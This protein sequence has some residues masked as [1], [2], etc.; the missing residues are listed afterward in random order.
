MPKK[1][2][3]VVKKPRIAVIGAGINGVIAAS[4][5]PHDI[6]DV[7][8]F[9]KRKKVGGNVRT[10]KLKIPVIDAD[11]NETIET[12][13]ID[14]GAEYIAPEDVYP[15]VHRGHAIVGKTHELSP[16]NLSIHLH[17]LDAQQDIVLPPIVATS[18]GKEDNSKASSSCFGLF[19]SSAKQPR[20]RFNLI[21][22]I[23][24]LSAFIDFDALI[25]RAKEAQDTGNET[26]PTLEEFVNTWAKKNEKKLRFAQ[27]FLYPLI[28]G[29]WGVSIEDIKKDKAHFA[30]AYL[31]A[32]NRWYEA[33]KGFRS[34]IEAFKQRYEDKINYQFNTAITK[35]EAVEIEGVKKYKL[36][37]KDGVITDAESKPR[38]YDQVITATPVFI[39]KDLLADID[40]PGIQQLVESYK[41]VQSFST[42]VVIHKDDSPTFVSPEGAMVNTVCEG[43]LSTMTMKKAWKVDAPEQVVYK[44]WVPPELAPD[45][46]RRPDPNKV[47]KTSLYT[48]YRMGVEFER[49]YQ[50]TQENQGNSGIYSAMPSSDS[51][52]SSL[53]AGLSVAEKICALYGVSKTELLEQFDLS[54]PFVSPVP[55]PVSPRKARALRP[56]TEVIET[57]VRQYAM[58]AAHTVE[59]TTQ[60]TS[61]P[62]IRLAGLCGVSPEKLSKGHASKLDKLFTPTAPVAAPSNA[63]EEELEISSLGM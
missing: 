2:K 15:Y 46:K 50:I 31:T 3:E 8:V 27:E 20:L 56:S 11:G 54:K 16:F 22:F 23:K 41:Q 59:L 7:D 30:F 17:N 21:E 52:N 42:H 32:G 60:D 62:N 6:V 5:L 38:L 47:I 13:Y 34:Y 63:R 53:M 44:S 58:S 39:T 49:A 26:S 18:N 10:L 9:E 33:T 28:A 40:V 29:G 1:V 14:V 24:D 45:D 25:K 35:I 4:A 51:Q 55:A 43:G 36:F 12:V 57:D 37:T 19:G 61:H 48:H